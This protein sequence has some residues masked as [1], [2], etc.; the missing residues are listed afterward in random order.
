MYHRVDVDRPPDAV[1]R[2]LTVNPQQLRAQLAYLK[3]QGIEGISMAQFLQRLERHQP[4]GRVAV[5][6]FDD[7]YADQDTYAVPL[8]RAFGDSATFYIVTGELGR[9]RHLTWRQVERMAHEGMDIGAHGVQHDDLSELPP[10]QQAYQIDNSVGALERVLRQ[11]IESYAYPSGRFNRETLLLVQRANVPL[12]VTT[13]PVYVLPP[14][15][16]FEMTRVRVRSDWSLAD[17]ARAL[18]SAA[19]YGRPVLR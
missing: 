3:S 15:N 1:G 2:Q 14:E 19:M 5:L 11:P 10:A 9:A 7:G 6:T 12:A 18:Q 13:D 4:L 16:R 8:L 17:F